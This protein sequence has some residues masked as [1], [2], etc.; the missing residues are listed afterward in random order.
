MRKWILA[1]FVMMLLLISACDEQTIGGRAFQKPP[2]GLTSSQMVPF[3]LPTLQSFQEQILGQEYFTDSTIALNLQ[4]RVDSA[5]FKGSVTLNSIDSYVRIVLE[6]VDRK[7]Y[8]VFSSDYLLIDKTGTFD[9]EDVCEETCSLNSIR[10]VFVRIE[11]HDASVNIGKISFGI[12]NP[13]RLSKTMATPV[14]IVDSQVKVKLE[15][16]NEM[17]L[18]HNLDWEAGETEISKLSYAEKK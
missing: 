13:G 15:K 12:P 8:L 3:A 2:A 10:P 17:K 6:D 16:I 1:V 5:G 7:E 9:F 18:K 4:Q 11:L 14:Q